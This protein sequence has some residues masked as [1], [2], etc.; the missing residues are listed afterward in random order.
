MLQL[1]RRKKTQLRKRDKIADPLQD[2]QKQQPGSYVIRNAI[3]QWEPWA[4]RYTTTAHFGRVEEIRYFNNCG[5][6]A[7]TNLLLMAGKRF[8]QL[9]GDADRAKAVY[10]RVARFGVRHLYFINSRLRFAHGGSACGFLYPQDVPEAAGHSAPD[11]AAPGDPGKRA[12]ISGVGFPAVYDAV[13]P[14]GLSE[15]PSAGLWLRGPGKHEDGETADLPE[16][17]RRPCQCGAVFGPCGYPRPLLGGAVP[18]A[19]GRNRYG[20]RGSERSCGD[21]AAGDCRRII[22]TSP[23]IGMLN[24]RWPEL[25]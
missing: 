16:G 10:H 7:L 17:Q 15:P 22:E 9:A 14:S 3:D 6:T 4:A 25:L 2:A 21:A 24:C 20:F 18:C 12:P 11:P 5:P 23:A 1:F 13:E 19:A 8:G